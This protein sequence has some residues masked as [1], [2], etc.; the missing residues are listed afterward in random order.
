MVMDVFGDRVVGVMTACVAV[1]MD[2][3]SKG[4]DVCVSDIDGLTG[5]VTG[6]SHTQLRL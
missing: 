6:D 2:G 5:G 1:S 4:V 3:D